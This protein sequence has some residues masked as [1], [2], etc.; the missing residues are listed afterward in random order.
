MLRQNIK[1]FGVVFIMMCKLLIFIWIKYVETPMF[2]FISTNVPV[3]SV[4]FHKTYVLL[5]KAYGHSTA[6]IPEHILTDKLQHI[7]S[8]ISSCKT[9]STY[10]M[11][12]LDDD[13]HR[14]TVYHEIL[15]TL[16]ELE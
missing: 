5:R 4:I 2:P 16:H 15:Y 6:T 14:H 1:E 11:K 9:K 10:W 13:F 3:I 8:T 7:R 12:P